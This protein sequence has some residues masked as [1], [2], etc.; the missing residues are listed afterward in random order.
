E[1]SPEFTRQA[2]QAWETAR[3]PFVSMEMARPEAAIGYGLEDQFEKL[4][5][6]LKAFTEQLA[7]S[8][9]N[10]AEDIVT[11][12]V[13][14]YSTANIAAVAEA[15]DNRQEFQATLRALTRVAFD[16][17]L[18]VYVPEKADRGVDEALWA[19][20]KAMVEEA[21]HSRAGFLA[22]MAELATKLLDSL[23]IGI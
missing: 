20:H 8:L 16:G 6:S 15:L 9:G 10:A 4:K 13:R 1:P 21:Q 3:I 17:D 19:I 18:Q 5:A 14:T 22:T 12:D 7:T 2:A 23:R 11:L